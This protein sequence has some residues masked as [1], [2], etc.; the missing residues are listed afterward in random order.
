MIP[1]VFIVA[2][3]AIPVVV[4]NI[5]IN[6]W[7]ARLLVCFLYGTFVGFIFRFYICSAQWPGP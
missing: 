3:F 5:L 2:F 1:W 6:D 7:T 4:A